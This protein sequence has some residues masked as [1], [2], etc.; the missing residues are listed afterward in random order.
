MNT[1]K[2][3]LKHGEITDRIIGAFY[4][5]YRTLGFGFL[6]SVYE[7]AFEIALR[8][9]GLRVQRQAPIVV[10]FRGHVVGEFRADLFV[11]SIVVVELKAGTSLVAAHEAQMLN[12]LRATSIEVGLLFNFGPKPEFKRFTYDNARKQVRVDP[13]SSAADLHRMSEAV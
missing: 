12:Y 6:E 4:D 1:D 2:H 11:E 10:S 7:A 5:V 9:I 3:G 13:C 8:D